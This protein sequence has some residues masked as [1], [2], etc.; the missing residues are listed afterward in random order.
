MTLGGLPTNFFS[1]LHQP[2]LDRD[3]DQARDVVVL[4]LLHQVGAVGVPGACKALQSTFYL[5]STIMERIQRLCGGSSQGLLL[6]GI[7]VHSWVTK[8]SESSVP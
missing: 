7:W 2:S 4:Q 3:P 5:R 8:C 1:L 6:N